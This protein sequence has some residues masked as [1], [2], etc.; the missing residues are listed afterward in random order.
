MRKNDAPAATPPRAASPA[1]AP[2]AAPRPPTGLELL[3][4]AIGR[5]PKLRLLELA[6]DPTL[7]DEALAPCLRLAFRLDETPPP[8]APQRP[9]PPRSAKTAPATKGRPA[10]PPPRETPRATPRRGL[11][12]LALANTPA[13]D[14]VAAVCAEALRRGGRCKRGLRPA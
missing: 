5:R 3:G 6:D 2:A 4:E 14:G 1:A 13:S 10:S 9:P 12:V 8:T 7:D 11:T